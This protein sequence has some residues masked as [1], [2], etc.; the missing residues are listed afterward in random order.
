[1]NE[2]V[3]QEPFIKIRVPQK[4]SS[5]IFV[6]IMTMLKEFETESNDKFFYVSFV[7]PTETAR[8][9]CDLASKMKGNKIWISGK[10]IEGWYWE[11]AETIFCKYRETCDGICKHNLGFGLY[12]GWHVDQA[13]PLSDEIKAKNESVEGL[14]KWYEE[15]KEGFKLESRN[16]QILRTMINSYLIAEFDYESK[17]IPVNK[18]LLIKYIEN[19]L[20]FELEH[21]PIIS[22]EKTLGLLEKIP[23]K[24]ILPVAAGEYFMGERIEDEGEEYESS[25]F[26]LEEFGEEI[27]KRFRKVLSEFFDKKE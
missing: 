26:T 23:E 9:F 14:V 19:K 6:D 10:E 21:C 17:E 5:I 8:K 12:T 20:K 27:E 7:E 13:H 18:E 4:S 16:Y 11:T 3:P 24:I 22:A 25:G 2:E 15:N 1:M